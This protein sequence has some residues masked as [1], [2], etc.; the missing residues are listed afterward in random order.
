M[1]HPPLHRIVVCLLASLAGAVN[2]GAQAREHVAFVSVVDQASGEARTVLE[3]GD[4]TI[5][6]DG[7]P[8]EVL[9][10]APAS[11]P[12]PIAVLV[13][14]SAAAESTVPDIRRGLSEFLRGLG[15]VGPVSL[16]GFGERPTVLTDYTS[17]PAALESGIGKVFARPGTVSTLIEAV[18]ETANGLARRESDRAAI[19]V[20]SAGAPERSNV[21]YTRALTSLRDSGASLHV[22]TLSLPGRTIFDDDARQRD[23]LFDRGVRE[24]GGT[25]RDVVASMGFPQAMAAVAQALAHQFRVVYARPQALIP[26]DTFEVTATAAGMRAYGGVARAQP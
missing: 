1:L 24:T 5:R 6:E 11:G 13:D 14:T 18:F 20:L 26:P 22:V 12:F 3:A 15:D 19:V 17:S 4:I 21:H 25:R 7:V 9:R 23:T 2:L 16:I 10:V 8:R